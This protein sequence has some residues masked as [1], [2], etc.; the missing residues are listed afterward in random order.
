MLFNFMECL[1]LIYGFDVYKG[2]LH[3]CFYMRKSLVCDMIEPFRPL[4]DWKIRSAMNLG[5]INEDEDFE[6]INNRKLLKYNKNGDYVSLFMREI[7]EHKTEMFG[8]VQEF[9]RKFMR[10]SP[11]DDYRMFE[12]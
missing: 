10:D 4:I 5:Q 11:I 7:M 9:Y 6:T 12:I 3:T 2:F 8:F 1:L